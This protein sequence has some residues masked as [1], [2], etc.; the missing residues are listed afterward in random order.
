M[1]DALSANRSDG[2]RNAIKG[3]ISV[4]DICDKFGKS[5]PTIYNYMRYF[6]SGDTGRIPED[7][8]RF[9]SFVAPGR[10]KEEVDQYFKYQKENPPEDQDTWAVD[11]ADVTI[12]REM[13]PSDSTAE[14][15][16]PD[17]IDVRILSD[18]SKAMVIFPAL[19][20]DEAVVRLFADFDG[21]IAQIAEYRPTPGA[22]FVTVEGLVSGTTFYCEVVD[23]STGKS[24]GQVPF[25]L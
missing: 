4:T 2:V 15:E 1:E 16:S 22:R 14:E 9:L 3:V 8:L 24:S 19:G 7:V 6:D 25:V 12:V 10:T 13:E 23:P 17:G 5:R 18:S 11:S 20:S 21:V